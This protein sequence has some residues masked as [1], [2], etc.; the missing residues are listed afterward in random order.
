MF[1]SF[2]LPKIM[3]NKL[4]WRLIFGIYR[5]KACIFTKLE[6]SHICFKGY[7]L[8][9]EQHR[10]AT[11]WKTNFCITLFLQAALEIFVKSTPNL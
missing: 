8:K 7:L 2:R 11:L 9:L 10:T 4:Q 1:L 5:M 3:K 6:L